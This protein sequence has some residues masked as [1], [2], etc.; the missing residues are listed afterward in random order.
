MSTPYEQMAL[1][2]PKTKISCGLCKGDLEDFTNADGQN[3]ARCVSCGNSDTL[4]NIEGI[5]GEYMK[6]H[7]VK[8]MQST[9]R[10]VARGSK[11]LTYKPG[12][13]PKGGYRFIVN[14]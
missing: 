11:V 9:L 7:L 13:T 2:E 14:L 4:D 12:L 10:K 3:S 5:I 1:R 6:E 8:G